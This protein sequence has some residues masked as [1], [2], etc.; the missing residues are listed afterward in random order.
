MN[1][2]IGDD[3]G[4]FNLK[5]Q[6]ETEL[7]N[8]GYTVIDVG[9]EKLVAEDDY[10]DFARAVAT[11]VA[12][13]S[14]GR[15]GIVIC[16][17]GFGVDIAANKVKGIRAALA[18]SPDHIYQGRHDDDVNVLALAA[19]FIT[20]EDAS[21][22]VKVFLTTPFA[23]EERYTRRIKKIAEIEEGKLNN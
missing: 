5:G 2:Y 10:T 15:R 8:D 11:Q 3:H 6:L 23:K 13:D 9:D 14:A 21:K 4:G 17:S 1:I 20:P 16:R 18:M 7:K 22:M 12:Q 19:D